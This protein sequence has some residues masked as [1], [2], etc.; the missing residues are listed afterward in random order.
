MS[1]SKGN[2]KGLNGGKRTQKPA[3]PDLTRHQYDAA[4]DD[5]DGPKVGLHGHSVLTRILKDIGFGNDL[6]ECDDE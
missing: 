1:K 2:G 6:V 3:A 4:L 5:D